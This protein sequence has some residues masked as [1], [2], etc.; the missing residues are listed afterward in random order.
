MQAVQRRRTHQRVDLARRGETTHDREMVPRLPL[1]EHGG[2]GPRC[3]GLDH[4]RQQVEARFVHENQFPTF[5]VGLSLQG[6]PRLDPPPRDRLLIPLDR[7]GDRDL[8]S[9]TEA[10][11]QSRDLA[12]AVRDVE[13][14]TDHPGDPA[15]GPDVAPE[16]VSLGAMPEEI[17]DQT[18]LLGG[19]PGGDAPMVEM[20]GEGFT[21]TPPSRS[22]P[23]ADATLAC[24]ESGGDVVLSPSLL[25][26]FPRPQSPP[27]RPVR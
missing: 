4:A 8:R 21:P 1:A 25:M 23:S 11:Q 7:A 14:L 20:R 5:A 16:A 27:F 15:T 12:L 24:P 19:Q 13:L 26:E 17:R 6:G 18:D 2:S 3:V 10:L 9:P 22:Q